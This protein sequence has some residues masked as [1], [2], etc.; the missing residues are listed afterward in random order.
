MIGQSPLTYDVFVALSKPNSKLPGKQ[1]TALQVTAG[2]DFSEKLFDEGA[3]A[4]K[5]VTITR[6]AEKKCSSI[7]RIVQPVVPQ[8][9]C[10][11][12]EVKGELKLEWEPARKM[13]V[14]LWQ[15]GQEVPGY[16]NG[17]RESGSHFQLQTGLY[18]LK[19]R[20]YRESRCDASIWIDVVKP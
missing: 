3:T 19:V 18:Q 4:V 1:D 17:F 14:E 12:A 6:H 2:I 16:P 20:E 15:H 8:K 10:E 9:A 5:H 13:W 11:N 7:P